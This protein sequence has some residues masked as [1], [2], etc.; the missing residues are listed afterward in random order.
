M[1]N[2]EFIAQNNKNYNFGCLLIHMFNAPQEEVDIHEI[3]KAFIAGF[4]GLLKDTIDG[5]VTG[6]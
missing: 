5:I 6:I 2:I 3:Y 4:A 1:L